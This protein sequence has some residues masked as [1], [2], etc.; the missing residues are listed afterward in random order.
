MAAYGAPRRYSRACPLVAGGIQR[1]KGEAP[2]L[3]LLMMKAYGSFLW[4]PAPVQAKGQA[5]EIFY[6]LLNVLSKITHYV[7]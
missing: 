1:N 4:I 5:L 2:L 3:L 7:E 6:N